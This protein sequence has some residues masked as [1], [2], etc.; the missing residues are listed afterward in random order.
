MASH[1]IAV[2]LG[3]RLPIH[4]KTATNHPDAETLFRRPLCRHGRLILT[5]PAIGA[6]RNSGI[7]LRHSK[8][9]KN[10]PYRHSS[11]GW[12]PCI[13]FL[14]MLGGWRKPKFLNYCL[15]GNDD[16]RYFLM[17]RFRLFRT[18]PKLIRPPGR[19]ARFIPKAAYRYC[20]T[21]RFLNRHPHWPRK[22][23]ASNS[24]SVSLTHVGRPWLH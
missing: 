2:Q 19:N 4:R 17:G 7:R 18:A 22:N 6:W 8:S 20:F 5:L 23:S 14:G 11:T 9:N 21:E 10:V 3:V 24:F 16:G 15:I 13:G 12:N 1:G